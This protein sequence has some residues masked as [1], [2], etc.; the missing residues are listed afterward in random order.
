MSDDPDRPGPSA[1]GQ[2]E[3]VLPL[4]VRIERDG[5]PAHTAALEAAAR[6]VL[7]VLTDPRSVDG[8]AWAAAVDAWQAGRIRKVV[9]RTRGAAWRRAAALPGVTVA[10][11]GAE[12]R[13]YPPVPLDGWPPEL[14]RL[15][16]AGTELSDP[17]P[18]PAVSG[19]VLWLNP[20]LTM[21]TGKAMAQVGHAAQLA[22]WALGGPART[23]WLGDGLDLHVRTAA[24]GRWAV[25]RRSGLPV[26]R[27]A[28]FTEIPPGSATVIA[29]LPE[30]A[31]A[32]SGG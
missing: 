24:A 15:Q 7:T 11:G 32:G 9:R 13:G 26:V 5:P 30:L 20:A 17:R 22:W 29:E 27:D 1:T 4:V 19:R 2:V 23:A 10:H 12:V 21:S 14:A 31:G 6:T 25:L 16:V 18:P 3:Y 28:G 8:G